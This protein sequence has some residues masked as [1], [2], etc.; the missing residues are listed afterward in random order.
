MKRM[1][2]ILMILVL[3]LSMATMV[4]CGDDGV[5]TTEATTTQPQGVNP[6]PGD[7]TTLPG[8]DGFANDNEANYN[9]A[10]SK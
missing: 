9:P 4:A 5:T 7:G 6:T 2:A 3:A 8:A 10:W 1:I